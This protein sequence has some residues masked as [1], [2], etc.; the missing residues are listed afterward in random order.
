MVVKQDAIRMAIDLAKEVCGP[1]E[2][3]TWTTKDVKD[4]IVQIADTI[5]DYC[6]KD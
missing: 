2:R 6:V 4:F 3:Y 1:N 5:M